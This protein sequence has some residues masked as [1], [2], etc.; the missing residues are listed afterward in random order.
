MSNA[1]TIQH[2]RFFGYLTLWMSTKLEALLGL[3]FPWDITIYF[4]IP[5]ILIHVLA[6]SVVYWLAWELIGSRFS[7]WI[8]GC[9]FL[10]HPIQTQAVT[11]ISQRFEAQ[12]A[13]FMFLAAVTFVRFRKGGSWIWLAGTLAAT[14]VAAMTK[15]NA[16][17]VPIWLMLIEMI[18]F[19]GIR[20][21]KK[22]AYFIPL[23]LAVVL[24]TLKIFLSSGGTLLWIPF[25]LYLLSQASVLLQYLK[26]VF[27]PGKQFL[28]Y[29][30]PP[31]TTVTTVVVL[32]W[33][34]ILSIVGL[35][36]YLARKKPVIGFGILTF[37]C[38]LSP[39]SVVPLPDMIFEH[40]VYPALAGLAIAVAGSSAIRIRRDLRV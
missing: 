40:R 13:L 10:V 14:F 16:V 4:R 27:L 30:F 24:P 32:E 28:L 21:L 26:L 29:D 6:A 1:Q 15:E 33:I 3:V 5:N 23:V 11:Y 25:E 17:A 22:M 38:L 34:A 35:G 39:T 12:A 18:F 9:L 19:S 8:A 36:I 7:A 31:V 20:S 2:S 37:F